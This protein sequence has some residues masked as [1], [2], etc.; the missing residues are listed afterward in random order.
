M[1][2]LAQT[3]Y[4]LPEDYL[5]LEA[6]SSMRH[7][8]TDGQI[9]AMAGA[10]ER[11]N[12]IALNV[13][14]HFRAATR[15]K[16][17][18]AY[19]SDMKLRIAASNAFYYPDVMLACSPDDDHPQYKTAPCAIVE[20]LSPSTAAIDRREKWLAYRLIS[21]LRVYLLVDSEQRLAEYW[22]RDGQGK[23]QQGRLEEN[24]VLNLECPPISVPLALDD[25]YEDVDGLPA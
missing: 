16:P 4:T 14:F 17:C 15:G 5:R 3:A 7:E 18:G 6:V 10:G 20:V 9:H 23:W 13:A 21:S 2:L 24:E 22:L 8:Y 12:R 25:L 19:I 1:S 11:H